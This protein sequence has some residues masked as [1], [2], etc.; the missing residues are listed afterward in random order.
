[1]ANA[2]TVVIPAY[3]ERESLERHLP[4]WLRWCALHKAQLIVVDDGSSDGSAEVLARHLPDRR[5]RSLLH[6][7][8]RGYGEAIKAGILRAETEYVATMD[9]DGQHS[10]EDLGRLLEV[11][12][13][14]GADLVIGVR[15]GKQPGGNY[16]RL[17]KAVIRGI[18]RLFFSVKITDLNSGMKVYRTR[19]VKKLL[20]YCPGSMAFSDVVTLSHLNLR[21]VVR[22]VPIEVAPRTE[23]HSTIDTMTALDTVLEIV[24]VLMWF[25]PLKIFLPVSALLMV[26]GAAWAIPFLAIGRGLSNVALLLM[27]TGLMCVILGLIAEQLAAVRRVDISDVIASDLTPRG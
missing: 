18:A 15:S 22:E 8:N 26:V 9:A 17:G 1:M 20:P 5:L 19:L 2:L 24:N 10:I 7:G 21:C 4:N 16:R 14:K 13:E 6:R 23:G 3:N 25:R 11:M 27:L 12:I